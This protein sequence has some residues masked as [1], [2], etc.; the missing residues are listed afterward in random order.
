M[1]YLCGKRLRIEILI[2][3]ASLGNLTSFDF[4]KLQ[5]LILVFFKVVTYGAALYLHCRVKVFYQADI[6]FLVSA[7]S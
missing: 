4:D 2:T 7:T 3:S 6:L 1:S 5:L